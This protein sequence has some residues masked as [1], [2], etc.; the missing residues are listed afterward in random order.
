MLFCQEWV[1]LTSD[2]AHMDY[3]DGEARAFPPICRITPE[4]GNVCFSSQHGHPQPEGRLSLAFGHPLKGFLLQEFTA[5][6][7]Q[8]PPHPDPR[9]YQI[10]DKTIKD[11]KQ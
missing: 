2:F 4:V 8:S 6:I 11:A 1:Q 9:S 3:P 7:K 5:H 10:D